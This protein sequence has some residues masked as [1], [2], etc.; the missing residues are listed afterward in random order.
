MPTTITNTQALLQKSFWH[1][2]PE[3]SGLLVSKTN[4][5][6]VGRKVHPGFWGRLF[7]RKVHV[8]YCTL[9][10]AQKGRRPQRPRRINANQVLSPAKS[11]EKIAESLNRHLTATFKDA[12]TQNSNGQATSHKNLAARFVDNARIHINQKIGGNDSGHKDVPKNV[13]TLQA[14]TF[15]KVLESVGQKMTRLGKEWNNAQQRKSNKFEKVAF[16]YAHGLEMKNRSSVT[17]DNTPQASYRLAYRARAVGLQSITKA[18]SH[19]NVAR[20]K[21]SLKQMVTSI[22]IKKTTSMPHTRARNVCRHSSTIVCPDNEKAQPFTRQE[23]AAALNKTTGS[24]SIGKGRTARQAGMEHLG[25]FTKKLQAKKDLAFAR[26]RLQRMDQL[27]RH[28]PEALA[29]IAF[30]AKHN[31]DSLSVNNF[32]TRLGTHFPE[33]LSKGATLAEQPTS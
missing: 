27:M 10:T 12:V 20:F 13:G 32:K 19:E 30:E 3:N 11:R 18:A 4:Q 15:K 6:V 2:L 31:P 7:G 8:A 21:T 16:V 1:N 28:L 17:N 5:L 24:Y 33:W 23:F 29:D 9:E 25:A 22:S 26:N 14:Q